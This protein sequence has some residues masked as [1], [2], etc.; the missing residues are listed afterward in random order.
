MGR[1]APPSVGRLLAARPIGSNTTCARGG[2]AGSGFAGRRDWPGPLGGS[3][4]AGRPLCRREHQ[5]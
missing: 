4:G 1:P 5:A 2:G 3:H